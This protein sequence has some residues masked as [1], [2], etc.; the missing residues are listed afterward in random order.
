MTIVVKKEARSWLILWFCNIL[1]RIFSFVYVN[2]KFCNKIL[3]FGL[4]QCNVNGFPRFY[5][6]CR[7]CIEAVVWNSLQLGEIWRCRKGLE[8]LLHVGRFGLRQRF[9]LS[10][11][12]F[13]VLCRDSRFGVA[14]GFGLGRVFLGRGH[15]CSLS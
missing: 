7:M 6:A 11:Q 1:D 10:W 15:G 9:S 14:T 13:L 5:A 12:S 8:R 4:V 2:E 3:F